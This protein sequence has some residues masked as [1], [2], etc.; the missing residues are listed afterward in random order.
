MLVYFPEKYVHN[1]S[2]LEQHLVYCCDLH[3]PAALK[4][5]CKHIEQTVLREISPKSKSYLLKVLH[6]MEIEQELQSNILEDFANT[7]TV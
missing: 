7:K 5:L 1:I 3:N 4:F 2:L 6:R